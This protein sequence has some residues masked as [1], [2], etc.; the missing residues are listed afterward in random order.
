MGS[1]LARS[2]RRTRRDIWFLRV[3]AFFVTLLLWATVMGGKP[4]EVSK[5]L[6]LEFQLPKNMVVAN[7]VSRTVTVRVSGP[8]AFLKEFQDRNSPIAVD[9]SHTRVGDYEVALNEKMFDIP[10]GLKVLSIVPPS[11][12]LKADKV[13]VRRVPIRA[14]F[15][16]TLPE[17]FK[18]S[19]VNFQPSTVELRG[20]ESKIFSIDSVPTVAITLKPNVLNQEIETLLNIQDF[21]GVTIEEKNMSAKTTIEIE[22]A[23]RRRWFKSIPV[24]LKLVS[25]AEVSESTRASRAIEIRPATVNF[26]LEG[27]E[28]VISELNLKDLEVWANV[29]ELVK[30]ST[31]VRL[32]WK[33]SPD[34][35]VVR[36]SSDWV[37]VTVP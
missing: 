6:D 25:G 8:R 21:P 2:I 22:G 19:K 31:R 4:G 37:R 11:L 36:R 9:L 14:V 23:L 20:P 28:K 24:R 32:D 10:L 16:G 33:L 18:V 5:T 3:V 27:P 26:L 30:G 15:S 35:R 34:L 1:S 29:E 17:G 7:Q 12:Q 13:A